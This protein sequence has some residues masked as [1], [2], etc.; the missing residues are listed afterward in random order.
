[1]EHIDN[2]FLD[3][4]T[5]HV[6]FKYVFSILAKSDRTENDV[7]NA[8]NTLYLAVKAL[9]SGIELHGICL[10]EDGPGTC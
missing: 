4:A 2:P 6:L 7:E 8:K 5:P 10:H 1:M 3:G 9:E